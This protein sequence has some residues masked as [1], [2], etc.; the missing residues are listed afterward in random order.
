[1]SQQPTLQDI[2]V[3]AI[4]P[5]PYQYRSR[6][7]DEKQ[8]QLVESLRANGLSTPILVRPHGDGFELVSGERRWRAAKELG[9]ENIRG[10][11]EEI[12]DAEAAM[13]TV[14]ENEVRTDVTIMEKAAGYRRLMDPPCSLT[15]EE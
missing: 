8:Q 14:T 1:M 2:P 9:W 13:R 11:C 7:D 12:T 6:F 4:H 10:I 5:S 15:L 3:I